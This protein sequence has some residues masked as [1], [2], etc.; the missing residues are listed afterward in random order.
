MTDKRKLLVADASKVVRASL[1]RQLTDR[2]A[3]REEASG[4]SAWQSLVLDSAIVAVVSGQNLNTLDG[5]GLLERLRS[6]KL[7]RLNQMPFFLVISNSFSENDRKEALARGVTDFIIKGENIPS[8]ASIVSAGL[9]YPADATEVPATLIAAEPP[10]G[11]SST[12]ADPDFDEVGVQTEISVSDV[13]GR[14][15]RLAGLEGVEKYDGE[16]DSVNGN[17]SAVLAL[18]ML[19]EYLAKRLPEAVKGQGVGVLAFG[20]DAYD[21]LV[22]RYGA[23]LAAR[24]AQKFSFLLARKIRAEDCIGELANGRVVIIAASTTS[25][26]CARFASRICKAMAAAQISLRGQRLDLTVSVGVAVV[27]ED[28]VALSG[29]GL[30][31]LAQERLEAA[32]QA[33]GNQLVAGGSPQGVGPQAC[34][35]FVPLLKELLATTDPAGL[36]PC[37]GNVGMQLMPILRELEKSFRFGLPLDEMNK[38]LWDRA[39]A[40]RM[41]N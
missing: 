5:F 3:V 38:R 26:I 29:E 40:E 9:A 27:P 28:A 2:F 21:E 8:V 15:G 37:L 22:A 14:F 11:I 1:V 13:M 7:A 19:E 36:Q 25:S 35:T 12:V 17:Q 6:N 33:G 41:L 31:Q 20:L 16:V 4:E 24:T 23:D 18:E 32:Q 30:L 34:D 39:R 10:A